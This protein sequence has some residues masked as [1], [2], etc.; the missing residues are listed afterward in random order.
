MRKINP[1]DPAECLSHS[2]LKGEITAQRMAIPLTLNL[3]QQFV[4]LLNR[5]AILDHILMH[6]LASILIS[7]RNHANIATIFPELTDNRKNFFID[8]PRHA[9]DQI[10]NRKRFSQICVL[11]ALVIAI[12][13]TNQIRWTKI[14][15]SE[16]VILPL[17]RKINHR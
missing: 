14:I 8:F 1:F 16:F 13:K 15:T 9:T 17:S 6:L 11:Y 5:R 2:Q 3:F 7:R 4:F 10:Q 12:S